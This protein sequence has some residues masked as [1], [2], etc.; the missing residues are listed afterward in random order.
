MNTPLSRI[1]RSCIA[2][3]MM[4]IHLHL[5]SVTF[6]CHLVANCVISNRTI[7]RLVSWRLCMAMDRTSG[8]L[9]ERIESLSLHSQVTL[10]CSSA[11]SCFIFIL[12]DK[13]LD[14][15]HHKEDSETG[16]NTGRTY[17]ICVVHPRCSPLLSLPPPPSPSVFPH[18][19]KIVEPK[20]PLWL[21]ERRVP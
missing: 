8:I 18:P 20:I 13:T 2:I 7:P 1:L 19:L 4:R 6:V 14:N 16:L 21:Y 10:S 11:T 5:R 15:K 12:E 3:R 9:G 17:G